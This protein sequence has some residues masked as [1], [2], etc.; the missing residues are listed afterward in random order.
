MPDRIGAS[1]D[2]R[3][4]DVVYRARIQIA[5]YSTSFLSIASR[6]CPGRGILR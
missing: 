3:R 6:E 2:L 4:V 1:Q 5:Q